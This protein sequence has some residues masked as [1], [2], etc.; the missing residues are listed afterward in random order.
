MWI[1]ETNGRPSDKTSEWKK[2]E[3]CCKLFGV[4]CVCVFVFESF[5][6]K[7]PAEQ[8]KLCR[9]LCSFPMKYAELIKA[10]AFIFYVFAPTF[11]LFGP[12]WL[13]NKFI[14][15]WFHLGVTIYMRLYLWLCGSEPTI[16][17]SINQI[18]VALLWKNLPKTMAPI[19]TMFQPFNEIVH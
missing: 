6:D 15:V 13:L 7:K 11:S 12:R 16:D 8:K 18:L 9:K 2:R 3:K 14:M 19:W 17:Y 5:R 4:C 10:L 1:K